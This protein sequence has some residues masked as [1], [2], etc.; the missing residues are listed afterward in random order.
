MFCFFV[1]L[2]FFVMSSEIKLKLKIIGWESLN[3]QRLF[4]TISSVIQAIHYK[5]EHP[6]SSENE[7]SSQFRRA[8][9]LHHDTFSGA[10]QYINAIRKVRAL[11]V[12]GPTKFVI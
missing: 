9:N 1:V 7:V 8:V 12:V 4:F 3:Q 5:Q 11:N 10:V 6:V 2:V